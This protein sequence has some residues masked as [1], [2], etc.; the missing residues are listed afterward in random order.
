M[1]YEMSKE[2]TTEQWQELENSL[3]CLLGYIIS[4]TS[5]S[6]E[7]SFEQYSNNKQGRARPIKWDLMAILSNVRLIERRYPGL[8]GELAHIPEDVRIKLEEEYADT[9]KILTHHK[10]WW[11]IETGVLLL[12]IQSYAI[13]LAIQ[14]GMKNVLER[15]NGEKL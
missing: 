13:I 12:E 4:L 11:W 7:L 6:I 8:F 14:R 3:K 2:Q 5:K 1:R 10:A 15:K 9:P